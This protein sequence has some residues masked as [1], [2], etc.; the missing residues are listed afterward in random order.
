M[1]AIA[2]VFF[3]QPGPDSSVRVGM[4]TNSIE[5]LPV[6]VA[7]P[8]APAV[9]PAPSF[10]LER[11]GW[12]W[13]PVSAHIRE[14]YLV[15]FRAPADAIARLVPAPLTVDSFRGQGFVSVCA[16]EMDDMGL[17]GTPSW[18]R[19]KNLELLYRVGVRAGDAPSFLTLRSDV[20]ARRLALL[21]RAFSHY[22]PHLAQMERTHRDDR[23]RLACRSGDGVGDA[24]FEATP[25]GPPEL[26][27]MFADA[28]E[29]ARFMLGMRFSVDVR[30]GGRLRAQEI[31][32]DPWGARF[33][34]PTRRRFAFIESLSRAI[35]APL[36]YD[37]TLVMRDL[38]QTWRAARWI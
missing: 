25:G 20:S 12:Q 7:A 18:L 29:A 3:A 1:R 32:H 17:A 37:H 8:P 34:T 31:D 16:L 5:R 36:I 21:G 10:A 26:N 14:R 6:P 30:P 27:A 2:T 9:T 13:L 28:A 15:T 11:A 35:G 19:W 4:E 23:F 22:R 33:A 24:E 38:R